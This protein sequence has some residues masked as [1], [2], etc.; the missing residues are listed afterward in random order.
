MI[1]PLQ[2]WVWRDVGREGVGYMDETPFYIL[3]HTNNLALLLLCLAFISKCTV[4][5]NSTPAIVWRPVRKSPSYSFC[6]LMDFLTVRIS[7]IHIW[8]EFLRTLV[9]QELNYIQESTGSQQSNCD[10]INITMLVKLITTYT[11]IYFTGERNPCNYEATK[12]VAK[13]AQ[14]KFWGSNGIW[15]N[16]LRDTGTMLY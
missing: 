6:I 16:D 11:V 3:K 5:H 9:L 13:K 15:I 1:P 7:F 2:L 10:F 12:A 4:F 14:K 8:G